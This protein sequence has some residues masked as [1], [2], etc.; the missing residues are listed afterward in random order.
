[1]ADAPP[2]APLTGMDIVPDAGIV[3]AQPVAIPEAAPGEA[4]VANAPLAVPAVLPAVATD[5]SLPAP[6]T[7]QDLKAQYDNAKKELLSAVARKRNVDKGLV[8]VPLRL[9]LA[10]D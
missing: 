2:Q 4:P 9:P 3:A 10:F 7:P 5:P 6:L 8:R 1:M